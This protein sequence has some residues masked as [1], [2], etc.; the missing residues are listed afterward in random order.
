MQD[1]S[2][3]HSGGAKQR[4]RFIFSGPVESAVRKQWQCL[5]GGE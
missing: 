3:R 2:T 4:D 5:P 1:I